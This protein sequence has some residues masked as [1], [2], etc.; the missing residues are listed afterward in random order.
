M[1][2]LND[3][4]HRA[5]VALAALFGAAILAYPLVGNAG[6]AQT[7]PAEDVE[8]RIKT[9]H[10]QLRITPEQETAWKDVAAAMR[11]NSKTM[12][13]LYRQQAEKE[14]TASAPDVI[15][16]YGQTM[17]AHANAI[18]KFA[19]AFQ[20]LYDDMS[21]TQKKTADDVFRHRVHDAAKRH[22]S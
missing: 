22:K 12:E 10:T 15:D 8:T 2:A 7:T 16:A 18:H 11:D 9:L 19:T 3:R 5:R 17:D 6:K 20:S 13:D 14:K 1:F 21:T 4:S